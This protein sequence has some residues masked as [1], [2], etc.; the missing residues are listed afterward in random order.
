MGN[1][2]DFRYSKETHRPAFLLRAFDRG[3]GNQALTPSTGTQ[4]RFRDRLR[5]E[6][7]PP[8]EQTKLL[9]TVLR[10]GIADEARPQHQCQ[11]EGAP[12]DS[13]SL[14]SST[15]TTKRTSGN[16]GLMPYA[17]T[18]TIWKRGQTRSS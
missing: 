11:Q 9:R 5:T 13:E 3:L 8:R 2:H 4:P 17:L 16:L 14:P 18:R 7:R 6:A 12:R 10:L 1:I 15:A